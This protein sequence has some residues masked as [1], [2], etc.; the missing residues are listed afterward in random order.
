MGVLSECIAQV[1]S[2]C[3]AMA[4]TQERRIYSEGGP[5]LNKGNACFAEETHNEWL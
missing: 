1:L 5:S 3:A 4:H 2:G